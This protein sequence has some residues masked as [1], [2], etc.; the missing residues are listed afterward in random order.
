MRYAR[1]INE[2][3]AS[4]IS[5]V[6]VVSKWVVCCALTEILRWLWMT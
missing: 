2:A 1:R 3:L 4:V 6:S 5:T